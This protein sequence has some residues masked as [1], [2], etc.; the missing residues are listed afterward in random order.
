[1]MM[2]MTDLV[3]WEIQGNRFINVNRVGVYVENSVFF[4]VLPKLIFIHD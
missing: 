1:M 2:L 4:L 3:I